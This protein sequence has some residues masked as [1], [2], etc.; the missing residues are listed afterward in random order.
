MTA[1][2]I[3][4]AETSSHWTTIEATASGGI[5][6]VHQKDEGPR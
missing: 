6:E 2:N 1:E 5:I 4:G 3:L